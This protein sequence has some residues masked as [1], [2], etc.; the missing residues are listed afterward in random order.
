DVLGLAPTGAA[1]NRVS[2]GAAGVPLLDLVG[3]P[4]LAPLD[5]GTAGLFHT[6]F[7]LP[8]RASIARWL[9]FV[10]QQRIRLL[11]A[12]DHRVSE[13]IYLADPEG[14]GIEVY[15]DRPVAE[16]RSVDG[17]LDMPSNPLDLQD[18]LRAADGAWSGMPASSVI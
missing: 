1:A 2:L 4:G 17:Q 8:D 7:L 15:A 12:S 3:D 5:R 13:A 11:G 18:L 14:N 10:V 6:A 9:G 16:W